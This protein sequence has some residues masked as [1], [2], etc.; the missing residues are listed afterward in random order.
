MPGGNVNR[1]RLR[2]I[3]PA[4]K[5]G[6][7]PF[8]PTRTLT[9]KNFKNSKIFLKFFNRSDAGASYSRRYQRFMP[10]K[11]IA[12]RDAIG[13]V[14]WLTGESKFCHLPPVGFFCGQ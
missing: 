4:F 9:N 5:D 11:L 13:Y 2:G 14:E 3:P 7:L 10:A 8:L 12:C 1:R 6:R